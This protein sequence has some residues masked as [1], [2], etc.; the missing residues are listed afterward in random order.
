MPPREIACVHA[1]PCWC[2]L[3][4]VLLAVILLAFVDCDSPQANA[5]QVSVKVKPTENASTSSRLLLVTESAAAKRSKDSF[6]NPYFAKREWKLWADDASPVEVNGEKIELPLASNRV[7][8][9]VSAGNLAP[10][11]TSPAQAASGFWDDVLVNQDGG[12]SQ[13]RV[14]WSDGSE[15]K[16]PI[17]GQTISIQSNQVRKVGG[18]FATQSTTGMG[19]NI[20]NTGP[21]VRFLEQQ[22]Y[23]SNAL[24]M[25]PAHTSFLDRSP[26][27]SN[28][29][30]HAHCPAFYN[31]VG[32]SGSE[33]WAV[34][35]M[36]I[37]GAYLNRKLK[38]Q[39]KHHGLYPA[40]MLYLWKA[41]LPY[42]VA[43]EHELRHRLAY[44]SKG[45]HSDYNGLNQT[46]F[47]HWY[48]AY[49]ER[50]HMENMVRLAR[51]LTHVPAVPVLD[52]K[53]IKGGQAVYGHKTCVL[54]T[55]DFS[56]VSLLVSLKNSY[57][58][59]QLPI[60]FKWLLLE[61]SEKTTVA[62]TTTPDEY[63]VTI[64][65]NAAL[66]KGRTTVLVFA[67]NGKSSSNPVSINV[68]RN[69]GKANR[70]PTLTKIDDRVVL[71]GET[72]EFEVTGEDPDFTKTKVHLMS[73]VGALSDGSYRWKCPVDEEERVHPLVFVASDGCGGF[74]SRRVL[75]SV[76]RNRPVISHHVEPEQGPYVAR[77]DSQNSTT[78]GEARIARR[79]W[80]LPNHS[81]P[82]SAVVTH[83]FGAPGIYIVKL[84]IQSDWGIE[85]AAEP[86]EIKHRWPAMFDRAWTQFGLS[87]SFWE[88]TE[89]NGQVEMKATKTPYPLLRRKNG[90]TFDLVSK[91]IKPPLYMECEFSRYRQ[92]G[93]GISV[94]GVHIGHPKEYDKND[95]F[96][97]DT[98]ITTMDGQQIRT[99]VGRH[100]R[101][102]N[103][104]S[105]LRLYVTS[106]PDL[107]GKLRFSGV[108]HA[109][110]DDYPF[111][112]GGI[113]PTNSNLKIHCRS[114]FHLYGLKIWSPK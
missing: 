57:D 67:D 56:E 51:E 96:G 8:P 21:Q 13:Q 104:P 42:N 50:Q 14:D 108:L 71:P 95:P 6:P 43:Y 36:M 29:L 39:I 34:S 24:R 75:L 76:Q 68:F 40:T 73:G 63:V 52:V 90:D 89:P 82:K 22:Y 85:V 16:I 5:Q 103:Q 45:D 79:Q 106:D 55:Q 23:F 44:Y 114:T 62:P 78:A 32:S 91:T 26:G 80:K 61:G 87:P 84:A 81:R 28:D 9:D 7:H 12:H 72:V 25:G 99:F 92:T 3:T 105:R 97:E 111:I 74:T 11:V 18:N 98:S 58:V 113:T 54:A 65:L 20:V 4:L 2:P 33:T 88:A 83:D 86:I 69:L 109:D 59:G 38:N 102:S 19:H 47:N 27:Q 70:R 1:C 17:R 107:P 37:A 35:K 94:F 10:F 49:D 53:G 77:L 101:S 100:M 31:S 46:E 48:H 110:L 15:I 64:P 41:G 93:S 66:P 60:Q 30:Y 112:V